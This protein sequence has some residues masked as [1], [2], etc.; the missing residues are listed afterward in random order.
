MKSSARARRMLPALLSALALSVALIPASMVSARS[1]HVAPVYLTSGTGFHTS[2][3]RNF[4]PFSTTGALDFT[5]GAIYEPL[6]IITTAGGGHRYPW[7]ATGYKW[8]NSNKTLLVTIQHGVKWSDGQPFT[9][10]DVAFTFNYGKTHSIA[11]QNGLWS[12]GFLKSVDVVGTD[13]VA[14]NFHTVDTTVLPNVVSNVKII[15]EH[16]WSKVKNPTTWTNPHPVGTGPFTQIAKFSSQEFILGKNPYY[17][18]PGKPTYDGIKVPAYTGND[19]ANLS[20]VHGELDW[21]GNFVPNIQNVYVKRDPA[22]F[23]YFYASD[24]VPIALN[25]NDQQYPY[26]LV[27]FRKAISL[28]IDRKKVWLIGEYGYEPPSDAVGISHEWPSWMP[29]SLVKPAKDLARYNPRAAKAMLAKAGFTWKSGTL[30]DPKGHKVSIQLSVISGWTDWVLS[31]QII[32]KNLRAIGVDASV[33]LMDTNL[34]SEKAYKGLLSAFLSPWMNGGITPY[35]LFQ[36]YMSKQSYVPTGQDA[37]TK[38]TNWERWWS[39]QATNLLAQFRQTT[40]S[41]TQHAI[42]AKLAKIQLDEMPIIPVMISAEWYTYSTLHFTGWVTPSHYYALG[43]PWQYP[44]NVKVMT[45][46][47]PVK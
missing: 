7:L 44:D 1:I 34:W 20:M 31:L 12:G 16:V 41:G 38:G 43:P 40:D 46:I 3:V 5:A 23:H 27:S 8:T 15:P 25:F 35:Y 30:Y 37:S 24:Q 6:Y 19:P 21:T 14:F 17:W 26:S 11:D 32:A 29:N 42:V 39:P 28:A 18:Q 33:K 13:Q 22:H 2:M 10:R 36:S 45:T 4:N 47:T 9:A